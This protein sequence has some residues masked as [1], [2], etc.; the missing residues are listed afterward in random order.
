MNLALWIVTGLLALAYFVG[1]GFKLVTPK[2]KIAASGASGQWVEDFGA[3]AVKAIGALE[4]LA[5]IGLVLPAALDIAPGLVP[6]AALG[7]LIIMVGAAVTR[8]RRH[9]TKLVVVDLVYI[10]LIGFVLWGR[11]GPESFTG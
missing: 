2:E 5:A 8:L 7:L 9:E 4:V 11:L 10:A 6:A 1:G 3:G